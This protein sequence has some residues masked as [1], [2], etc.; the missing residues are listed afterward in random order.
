M[1]DDIYNL[2]RKDIQVKFGEKILYG[3]DCQQLS[4]KIIEETQRH[5]SISTVKRFF[6]MINSPFNPSKYTLETFAR[7]LGFEHW[8]DYEEQYKKTNYNENISDT[9]ELLKNRILKITYQ[10]LE[11]MKEKAKY[12]SEKVIFRTYVKDKFDKFLQ[13]KENA[14]MFVA[15]LGFGKTTT[16]IQLVENYFLGEKALHK[17]DIIF[18]IDGGIFFNLYSK[19]SNFELFNQFIE[20]KVRSS[21]EFYFQQNPEKRKGRVIL[22]I[23]DVDE[24]YF[25]KERYHSLMENLMRLLMSSENSW[26]K[27][28][29]TCRPENL[30]IFYYLLN[31]N[32]MLKSSWFKMNFEEKGMIESRN[33]PLYSKEEVKKIIEK[34]QLKCDYNYLKENYNNILKI[35]HYPYLLSIFKEKFGDSNEISLISLLNHYIKT[36]L[37]SP[38]YREDK[39]I[40]IDTFI[41]LCDY[42]KDSDAVEKKTLL[43]KSN[44]NNFAYR[45][46]ISIGLIYEYSVPDGLFGDDTFVKFHPDIFFEYILFEKWR[47]NEPLDIN[48]FF[49]I[50]ETYRNKIQLQCKLLKFFIRFLYYERKI[51]IL[52]QLQTIFKTT[53][54]TSRP[55]ES[56]YFDSVVSVLNETMQ[57]VNQ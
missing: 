6:G 38:P 20:F 33:I 39:L 53:S 5:I 43:A 19:S 7:Y 37:N 42:G 40:I 3:K 25:D 17:N 35:L 16:I 12:D 13:S 29:M 31:K 36:R 32:P 23:D 14:T 48:L 2:L 54:F 10:S 28:V 22:I 9:W 45:E 11:S 4:K 49:K 27:I 15:P 26:F 52:Q 47:Q 46:L 18:V 1:D 24:V 55:E 21:I 50:K 34:H 56:V 8:L 57:T 51:S 30:D 44:V 41:E